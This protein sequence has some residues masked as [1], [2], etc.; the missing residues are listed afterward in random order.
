[1]STGKISGEAGVFELITTYT[2]KT[3]FTSVSD[4]TGRIV[5]KVET[6]T[7]PDTHEAY[8]LA[9]AQH[10][11]VRE[12]VMR[13]GFAAAKSPVVM[14][15]QWPK[16][17][18]RYACFRYGVYE[19]IW[20]DPATKGEMK[21]GFFTIPCT[22][23]PYEPGV[24]SDPEALIEALVDGAWGVDSNHAYYQRFALLDALN[25]LR[26]EGRDA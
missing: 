14:A 19:G 25:A 1:M 18:E 23:R 17:G 3:V 9:V 2:P 16:D 11:S 15:P 10:S 8:R 12:L 6:S 7:R 13:P 20:V 22:I 4:N 24:P 5:W 21:A 26:R